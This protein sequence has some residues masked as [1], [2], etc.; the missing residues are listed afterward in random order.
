MVYSARPVRLKERGVAGVVAGAAAQW[1]LPVLALAAAEPGALRRAATGAAALL[2]LAIGVRW[3]A[4][5]QLS[6]AENDRRAGVRTVASRGGPVFALAACAFAAELIL[7]AALFALAWPR[8]LAPGLALA[9]WAAAGAILGKPF[10]DVRIRLRAHH[11]APLANYYRSV[12]P[13]AMLLEWMGV[14]PGAWARASVAALG[15]PLLGRII[16]AATRRRR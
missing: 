1:T 3:M 8:S 4:M 15:A 16:R 11:V 7:L 13:A 5:H 10:R 6:D 12:F 2:A 14:P 9:I